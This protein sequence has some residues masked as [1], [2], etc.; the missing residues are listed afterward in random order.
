MNYEMRNMKVFTILVLCGLMIVSGSPTVAQ[1]VADS[2]HEKAALK[3]AKKIRKKLARGADFALLARK[4]SADP[5]SAMQGGA[6]GFVDQGQ[7]VPEFERAVAELAPG[8]ISTPVRTT[9][10]YHIIELIE[11][12]GNKFK[13]RHILI[14]P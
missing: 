1:K 12:K 4:Y 14:K 7:F 8:E 10:G 2:K 11:R 6:L 3:K 9:F 13:A 5:G